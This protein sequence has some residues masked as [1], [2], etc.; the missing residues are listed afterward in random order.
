MG[1]EEAALIEKIRGLFPSQR[2][3]VGIGDDAAI[4]A[5]D[6][7]LVITTDMLVEGVDFTSSTPME[8]V[9]AKSLAANLSDLAAMGAEPLA[10][11]LAAGFPK[12]AIERFEI[13]I[14][15]LAKHSAEE[16]IELI[17]GD[18]SLAPALTISITAL[19]RFHRDGKPLLRRGA[20][21]GNRIFVSRPLGGSAAGFSLIQKGWGLAAKGTVSAPEGSS[22]NYAQRELAG[23]ALRQHLAPRAELALGKQLA[24]I[25]G[26]TACIDISDGLSTDL[27]HLCNAAGTGAVVE[28]ERIPI[29]SELDTAGRTL[30]VNL[31]DAV[32]H[33]GE[34]FALLFTSSLREA[35]LSQ[36]LGRPVYAIGKIVEGSEVRLERGGASVPLAAHGFDHFA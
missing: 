7:K 31:E 25:D 26:I 8:F 27:H 5:F 20:K 22:F 16:G 9:A 10:F 13:F 23:A 28:W 18:L 33:G 29:F 24:A 6:G 34:E 30:G 14:D 15:S 32:L 35:E 1:R 36:R 3:E 17:G 11:T 12:A 4:V 19:G 2:A 21:P